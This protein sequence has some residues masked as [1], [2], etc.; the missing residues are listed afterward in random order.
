MKQIGKLKNLTSD[1]IEKSAVGIGFECLDRQ[2]F[3]P[4]KCYDKLA[5]TGAKYARCQTGWIRCEKQKGVYTFEW[6]DSVI[7]NLLCRGI[8]PWLNIGLYLSS[9][10]YIKRARKNT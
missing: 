5:A 7:D 4:E 9:E 2:V 10:T 8:Q 1:K 6:L 3:D